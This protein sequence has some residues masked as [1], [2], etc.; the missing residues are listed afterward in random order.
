MDHGGVIL[1]GNSVVG[2]ISEL[3]TV[4]DLPSTGWITTYDSLFTW[5]YLNVRCFFLRKFPKIYKLRISYVRWPKEKKTHAKSSVFVGRAVWLPFPALDFSSSLPRNLAFGPNLSREKNAHT[6]S[7]TFAIFGGCFF[8]LGWR[9]VGE[10]WNWK[11]MTRST[12]YQG[13]RA[14]SFVPLFFV[15]KFTSWRHFFQPILIYQRMLSHSA[16]SVSLIFRFLPG[17]T[18]QWFRVNEPAIL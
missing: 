17:W 4:P 10:E 5:M 18:L 16:I 9:W 2:W 3:S 14:K 6:R 8:L 11:N 12:A 13:S 15:R 7:T 1:H